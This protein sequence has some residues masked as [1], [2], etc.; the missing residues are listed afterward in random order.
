MAFKATRTLC[1]AFYVLFDIYYGF[2]V[3]VSS[4]PS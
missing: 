2:Y 3:K 1:I 4:V